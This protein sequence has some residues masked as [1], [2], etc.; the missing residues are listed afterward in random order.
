MGRGLIWLDSTIDAGLALT[1]LLTTQNNAIYER[2]G[3][4][5]FAV[6]ETLNDIMK[7]EEDSNE[8]TE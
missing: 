4:I 2:F 7:D 8:W 3:G 1:S 6:C 5:L